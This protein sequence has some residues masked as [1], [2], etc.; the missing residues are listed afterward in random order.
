MSK[1]DPVQKVQEMYAAFGRGDVAFIVNSLAPEATWSVDG[2]A[3]LPFFG[4]RKGPAGVGQ[5]FQEIGMNLD[6]QEF[7]PEQFFAQGNTV[8][9]LG[10]ERGQARATGKAFAGHWAHVF[11]FNSGKVVAFREYCN[12]G[13]FADAMRGAASAAA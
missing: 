4:D 10:F 11:T 13:A 8:I 9:V 3:G 1:F 5:F 6:I 12:S 7:R 2:P